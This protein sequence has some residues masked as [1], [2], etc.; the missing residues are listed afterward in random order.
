MKKIK[1]LT[2]SLIAVGITA[3]SMSGIT[4]SADS[5]Y[6]TLYWNS[7]TTAT[8]SCSY[9]P[10]LSYLMKLQSDNPNIV[11]RSIE[12]YAT[13]VNGEIYWPTIHSYNSY[14]W[15]TYSPNHYINCFYSTCRASYN[16][17]PQSGNFAI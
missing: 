11:N 7:Y 4:A 3:T 9:T 12:A 1:S 6:R 17:S 8:A 5:V 2:A 14:L 13:Y 16:G 15:K 10:Q